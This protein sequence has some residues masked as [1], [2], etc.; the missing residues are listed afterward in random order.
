MHGYRGHAPLRKR[1][2]G[3]GDMC[4][5]SVDDR[6]RF[7][8]RRMRKLLLHSAAAPSPRGTAAVAEPY[9]PEFIP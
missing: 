2:V 5:Q 7:A 6:R 1:L 3:R 8:G 4:G 9:A